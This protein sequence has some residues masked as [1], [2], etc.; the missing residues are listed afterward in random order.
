[1]IIID[2]YLLLLYTQYTRV[3]MHIDR[4]NVWLL[5]ILRLT[6]KENVE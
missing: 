4:L 3:Q 6:P 1:M 2:H 5:K